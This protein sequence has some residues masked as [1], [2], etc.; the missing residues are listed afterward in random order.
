MPY[1]ADPIVMLSARALSQAIHGGEVSCRQVMAAYLAHIA[2]VNPG[3]NAIVAMRDEAALMAE[4]AAADEALAA[5][6]SAG[7]MHG[8]PQAPKDLA[9]TRGIRTTFGSPIYKDNVPTIDAIVV[10]RAR[11]AGAILI[12]KT[13]TPEFALG[14]QT[15]NPVFGTTLNPYDTTKTAGG[16]S[17]GAGAALALHLLPV[18]V[19]TDHTGSLR[20]PAAFNNLFSLRPGYGRVPAEGPDPFNSGM[21][22]IGPIARNVPDLAQTLAV[23]AGYDARVPLSIRQDPAQFAAPLTGEVRGKRVAWAGDLVSA[24]L[25]FEPEVLDLCRTAVARLAELGCIVE[26]AAPD[27]PVEQLYP[28]WQ[29]LRAWQVGATL[30]DLGRDPERRAQLSEPARFELGLFDRLSAADINAA[31]NVRGAWYQ[32]VRQL[33]ERYDYFV[34]PSAQV[35]PFDAATHWPREIAGWP[36]DTYYRWM[37]AMIPVTM[38]GCPT[39]NVPAGFNQAGLPMGLQIMAPNHAEMACLELAHAYDQLTRWVERHPPPMLA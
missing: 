9:M 34:L 19:G 18:A 5:G 22:Q 32:A 25:P 36:M 13:N 1:A 38:A 26:E 8:M 16:S 37:E 39:V 20:N 12:G 28:S 21:S 14:S 35:F 24:V 10:E 3:S 6:R 30:G 31:S 11:R 7:W 29:K 15:H 17:G 23:L 27:F 33:F 4:A 2:Q